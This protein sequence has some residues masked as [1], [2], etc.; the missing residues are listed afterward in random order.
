MAHIGLRE[1]VIAVG[2]AAATSGHVPMAL[3]QEARERYLKDPYGIVPYSAINEFSVRPITRASMPLKGERLRALCHFLWVLNR[4]R[5]GIPTDLKLY[6]FNF[7]YASEARQSARKAMLCVVSSGLRAFGMPPPSHIL[8]Q[9]RTSDEKL[10]TCSYAMVEDSPFLS[11]MAHIC[12]QD[13][14][15]MRV[16]VPLERLATI[17]RF[18]ED[19]RNGLG[20]L[21]D[22]AHRW[23]IKSL[24]YALELRAASNHVVDYM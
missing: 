5:P 1:S 3:W 23:K 11:S 17:E 14:T 15:P 12:E 20:D 22:D 2:D 10:F 24:A 13:G 19:H 16:Q 21:N 18:Y 7:V 4:V 9:L 6:M 8:P